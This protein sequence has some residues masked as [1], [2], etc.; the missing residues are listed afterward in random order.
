MPEGCRRRKRGLRAE[1]ALSAETSLIPRIDTA[2]FVVIL[3]KPSLPWI[4]ETSINQ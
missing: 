4:Y 1:T 3:R 2:R